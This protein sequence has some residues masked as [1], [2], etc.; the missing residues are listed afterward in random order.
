MCLGYT[1]TGATLKKILDEHITKL[2]QAVNTPAYHT[3]RPLDIIVLTD[4]VPSRFP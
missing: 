3:I 1:P 2:D 4:G